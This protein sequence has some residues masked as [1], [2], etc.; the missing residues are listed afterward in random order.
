MP[1]TQHNIRMFIEEMRMLSLA[2]DHYDEKLRGYSRIP[3][4]LDSC[5]GDSITKEAV[6]SPVR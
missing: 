2:I 6:W 5:G 4:T 3:R 1:A